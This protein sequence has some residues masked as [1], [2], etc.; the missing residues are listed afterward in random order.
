MPSKSQIFRLKELE[1][2]SLDEDLK[3][4]ISE[5]HLQ[6]IS[7]ELTPEQLAKAEEILAEL[8]KKMEDQDTRYRKL[9]SE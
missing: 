9:I 3:R 5:V 7:G 2:R 4:K 1:V 8:K 6:I